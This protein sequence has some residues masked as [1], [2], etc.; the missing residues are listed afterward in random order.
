MSWETN[1]AYHND[2]THVSKSGLDLIRKAPAKYWQR[3]L[4]PNAPPR[5]RNEAFVEGSAFHSIIL[6]PELFNK[7]FVIHSPFV[8]EGSQ[9]RKKELIAMNPGKDL[10]S[11]AAYDKV[12]R[13]R[14]AVM[15]H[16]VAKTLVVDGFAERVFK[17]TD[18]HTKV[19]CKIKPDFYNT[20]RNVCLDLKSTDDA[21]TYKF[22]RSAFKYRYHVQSPFYTDGLKENG[23]NSNAFIFIAV[24]KE[25]PYLVNVH[26]L[27]K[28]GMDLGRQ[29]YIEDLETYAQCKNNNSWPGYDE[30]IT[31]LELPWGM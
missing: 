25:P 1:E 17:W 15:A 20:K 4:N 7:E 30:E 22:S 23:I 29:T 10:L 14:D 11:I 12:N 5:K 31:P 3:Y 6:E 18:P 28:D 13:M 8:G 19:K 16:P 21:S 24:E 26:F 9:N 27:P 2:I